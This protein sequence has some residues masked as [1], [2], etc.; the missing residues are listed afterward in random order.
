MPSTVKKLRLDD[1]RLRSLERLAR[2]LR[3]TESEVLR[4]GLDL[5]ERRERRKKGVEKLIAFLGEAPEP[6][7]VRFRLR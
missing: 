7:K 3:V 6:P 2:D 1:R 5:V 4:E